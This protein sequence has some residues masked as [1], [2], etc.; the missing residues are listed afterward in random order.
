M[1]RFFCVVA[2]AILFTGLVAGAAAPA[3]AQ[4]SAGSKLAYV[5]SQTILQQTPGYAKAEST[6]TKEVDG[7]RQEVQK[8]QATLDS[9]ASDFEQQSVMLSPTAR[10]AKR[11]DLQTQQDQLQQ[12]T[13]ALRDK[14]NARERE[15][16]DPIRSRISTVI[17]GIR[18][19]GNY[20]MIFDV[21]ASNGVIVSA[22]KTL[23][24]TAKV[25]QR[26]QAGK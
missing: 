19:E 3:Q 18:A 20:A 6:F 14:A 21:T 25:V 17:D 5:N 1:K 12:R 2:S 11:K 4:A 23:D 22:D 7:Y 9:A 24:I 10:T 16:L 8:L 13:D 26:L 15:L